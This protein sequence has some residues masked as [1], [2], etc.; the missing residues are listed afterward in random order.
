MLAHLAADLQSLLP[1][2]AECSLLGWV[3][4]GAQRSRSMAHRELLCR[5]KVVLMAWLSLAA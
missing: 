1:G 2:I 3:Q 5:L 4:S